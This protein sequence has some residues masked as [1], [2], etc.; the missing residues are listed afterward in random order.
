MLRRK[1]EEERQREL[2]DRNEN[3]KLQQDVEFIKK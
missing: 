1:Q 3:I 2:M